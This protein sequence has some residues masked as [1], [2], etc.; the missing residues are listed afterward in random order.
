[1]PHLAVLLFLATAPLQG[2]PPPASTSPLTPDAYVARLD[3]LA[4]ALASASPGEA[5]RLSTGLSPRWIVETGGE[6]AV[7]DMRWLVASLREA[8][9]ASDWPAERERLGRRLGVLRTHALEAMAASTSDATR[10]ALRATVDDVLKRPEFS[11]NAGSGWREQLQ[12]LIVEWLDAMLRGLGMAGVDGRTVAIGL[13]WIA[14]LTALAGLGFWIARVLTAGSAVASPR[15][16]PGRRETLSAEVWARRAMTALR[17]GDAREA[18]RC[19]YN[20]ALRRLEEEGVWRLDRA[21]TPR[22]YLRLLEPGDERGEPVR[23]LADLFERVWYGNHVVGT[24]EHARVG[25]TLERLGCLQAGGRA[26]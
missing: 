5:E 3:A 24:G 6:P 7:V 20:G 13:A 1:M 26:I 2:A 21:R 15:F 22:E 14:G 18:V 16:A 4:S 10:T 11:S 12:R 23:Y 19:A 25:A 8:P 9:A 17:N